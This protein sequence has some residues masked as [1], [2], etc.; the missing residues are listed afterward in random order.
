MAGHRKLAVCLIFALGLAEAV[1]E[2][3]AMPLAAR[4]HDTLANAPGFG[5]LVEPVAHKRRA[6]R[7][8][9]RGRIVVV[10]PFTG[11]VLV[12]PATEPRREYYPAYGYPYALT[13]KR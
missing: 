11:T 8:A 9:R 4:T 5:V 6:R 3:K 13:R 10:N 7:V 12:K 1:T 2:A